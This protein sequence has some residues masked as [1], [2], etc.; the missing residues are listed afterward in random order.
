MPFM[1][2]LVME[3]FMVR[4]SI[5]LRKPWVLYLLLSFK[6]LS[7]VGSLEDTVSKIL[8][9]GA[10]VFVLGREEFIAIW[11]K[12][13]EAQLLESSWFEG[14]SWKLLCHSAFIRSGLA[15]NPFLLFVMLFHLYC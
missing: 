9:L 7:F 13:C 5:G 8:V 3:K 2:W 14:F 1:S 15:S 4:G 12:Y 6:L 11:V 10:F